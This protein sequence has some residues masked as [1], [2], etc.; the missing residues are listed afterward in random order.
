MKLMSPFIEADRLEGSTAHPWEKPFGRVIAPGDDVVII[1]NVDGRVRARRAW[2]N[3][4][5]EGRVALI[6]ADSTRRGILPAYTADQEAPEKPDVPLRLLA[7]MVKP[8]ADGVPPSF[9]VFAQDGGGPWQAGLIDIVP[10]DCG[11]WLHSQPSASVKRVGAE[12]A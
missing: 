8:E 10:E 7:C 4:T 2:W 11:A 1:L 5:D 6:D 9:S 3:P 12:T